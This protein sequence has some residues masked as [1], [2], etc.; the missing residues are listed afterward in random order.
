MSRAKSSK[1]TEKTEAATEESAAARH[2]K[3]GKAMHHDLPAVPGAQPPTKPEGGTFSEAAESAGGPTAVWSSLRH[4]AKES[5]L[6]RGTAT[7]L[8][9]NQKGGVDCPGCAWPDPQHR[10]V[11]E[12]C[13]N[14]AKAVA[15]ETTKARVTPEF[16]A[17]HSVSDLRKW[18]DY[19]LGKAGR[20]THPMVLREGDT[21][22]RKTSWDDALNL[23][24]DELKQ[25]ASPDRNAFY[26]SGRTSNEAAWLYQLFVRTYGT[27]NLPDC[28]NM[29][30]E[31]SG[32]GLGEVI[33]VGKG[34]VRLEDF[35]QAELI[36]VIGQNPG[37][38]HPRMLSALQEAKRA[39]ATIVTINP[40]REAGLLR[41]KNPQEVSGWLGAG[42]PLTD[43]YLQVRVNGDVALLNGTMKAMLELDGSDD[44]SLAHAFIDQRT[45]DF[46][47]LR[48]HL[49]A[50]RW[51]DITEDSGIDEAT[52][53]D[54]ARICL[55]SKATI[56]CWAMGLTQHRNGVANIQSVVNLLLLGGHFGRPGAGACPVRG[57]SNVQGDRT[58]GIWERPSAA[59]IDRLDARYQREF[60]REHGHDVVGV[61]EA[62]LNDDIDVF[63]A[64]GGN[65]LS[66]TP[67]T[68]A[69]ARGLARCRL[70][71]HVSTKLN[72]S[73][74]ITG[75]TALILPCL[76]RTE[77]DVQAGTRQFVTVENS[78]GYVHPSQGK[79]QPASETLRSEP[80]IVAELA[81]RVL[82]E[83]N[84]LPWRDMVDD[85]D[86]IRHEIAACVP[87]FEDFVERLQSDD[88]FYLPNIVHEGGFGTSDGLAHFTVHDQPK[89]T[90]NDG[91][92]L[93]MTI[94]SHDQYNTTIYGLN[95]R[96]RGVRNE[97]RVIF[98]NGEDLKALGLRNDELVD[99]HGVDDDGERVAHNFRTL[100]AELPRRSCATYFPEA[101]VLVPLH[102]RADKSR[103]PAS[104]SIVVRL[105]KAATQPSTQN[106]TNTQT[107]LTH[108]GAR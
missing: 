37:T 108:E 97:R 30:H 103:T 36:I 100:A 50:L 67:D 88:G 29:C 44:L 26:T 10:A 81:A 107:Q 71:A 105:E 54:F 61:I 101:N 34:T 79:L 60:P 43:H 102:A 69:T 65:F 35:P 18:S 93:M 85:Y 1:K 16:F 39:G 13:E 21:H 9:L 3:G 6:L 89:H 2:D 47:K 40:L 32:T 56:A 41:F 92:L 23:I 106:R 99:I 95:D 80:W 64:M 48:E 66:A 59:F 19:E 87:G 8:R 78:M 49:N 96:Y 74:L 55:T 7:L 86:R 62:M 25:S 57:H 91:E 27:N 58:M 68:E 5:G 31:S 77:L 15:E 12:F 4:I 72:R 70:T 90:L 38:N 11:A 82:G 53:R 63:F 28:S 75:R 22:Y 20:I 24:A 51:K 94:R 17:A 73:H 33:G 14:G 46:D 52:I 42:T 98:M 45:T 104:K 83:R 76:G 84:P